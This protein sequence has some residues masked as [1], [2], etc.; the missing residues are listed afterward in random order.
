MSTDNP[1]NYREIR[2]PNSCDNC[3]NKKAYHTQGWSECTMNEMVLIPWSNMR[4]LVCDKW[5]V[6][7]TP[8][9]RDIALAKLTKKEKELLGL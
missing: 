3:N 1:N 9:E 4:W 7:Y 5:E 8:T 6:V 2:K